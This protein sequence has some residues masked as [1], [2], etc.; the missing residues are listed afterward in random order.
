MRTRL[1]AAA[2]VAGLLVGLPSGAPD[3]SAAGGAAGPTG[4]V[5]GSVTV[6][7]DGAP[8]ADRSGIAVYLEGVPGALPPGPTRHVRQKD[9]N[10]LPGITVVTTGTTVEF[11]NEDKVFHNV[12]SVSS[13]A[14]FDLGLYKSGTSK[15]VTLKK[16]GVVDVYC[17]IH[18]QMAARIKVLDTAFYAVTGPDGAFRIKDVPPGSY[19]VVAWQAYGEE[20][21]GQVTVTAGGVATIELA[22]VEGKTPKRHLRKDGTPY[23]RYK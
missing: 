15:S 18:P 1:L 16:P 2:I 19:P 13:A 12:F 4:L 21:R 6:L 9:L 20:K 10:F 8:K 7:A 14:R 11:P 22:L 23:G 3:V 5:A 17:N